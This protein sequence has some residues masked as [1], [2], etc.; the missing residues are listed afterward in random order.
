MVSDSNSHLR[1][2][3]LLYNASLCGLKAVNKL[4]VIA[5]GQESNLRDR[6]LVS[7]DADRDGSSHP[8]TRLNGSMG[9]P[10][11]TRPGRLRREPVALT[12]L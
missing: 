1:F 2:F 6:Y 3:L 8:Y 7:D 11:T 9:H 10:K 12:A 5:A 4:E